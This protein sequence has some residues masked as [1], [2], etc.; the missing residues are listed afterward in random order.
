MTLLF[1]AAGTFFLIGRGKSAATLAGAET[2]ATFTGPVKAIDWK[3]MARVALYVEAAIA[4]GLLAFRA[5]AVDALGALIS[6]LVIAFI[7]HLFI[8]SVRRR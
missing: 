2:A 1:I 3:L 7:L 5:G 4:L 6:G 8:G